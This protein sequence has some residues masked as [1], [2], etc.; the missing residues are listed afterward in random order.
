MI[1]RRT[2]EKFAVTGGEIRLGFKTGGDR[3][4]DDAAVGVEQQL[5]GMRQA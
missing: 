3:Y 2:A 5:L 1:A 4:I